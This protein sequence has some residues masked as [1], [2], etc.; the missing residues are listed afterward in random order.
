MA[1]EHSQDLEV[2]TAYLPNSLYCN[3]CYKMRWELEN[4][5][6]KRCAGCSAISY[7]GKDCQRAAW[8]GHREACHRARQKLAESQTPTP[9]VHDLPPVVTT[10]LVEGLKIWADWIHPHNLD[11]LA[12]SVIRLNGG[13]SVLTPSHAL[14]FRLRK[15]LINLHGSQW[16]HGEMFHLAAPP[17]IVSAADVPSSL[18][19]HWDAW[20]TQCAKLTDDFRRLSPS[21]PASFGG[22][23]PAM[24][25]IVDVGLVVYYRVLVHGLQCTDL[26]LQPRDRLALRDVVDMCMEALNRA[27]AFRPSPDLT[28]RVPMV[29]TCGERPGLT[30]PD[31]QPI[32]DWDWDRFLRSIPLSDDAGPRLDPRMSWPHVL[33]LF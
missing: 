7:C 2:Q 19:K 22:L 31:W 10:T 8:K 15:S 18:L 16:N 28:D 1:D 27:L 17:S 20:T 23:R 9:H 33:S 29:G 13:A 4:T 14:V 12:S 25:I 30:E 11:F 6:L 32:E 5:P 3:R 21:L 26:V 24:F